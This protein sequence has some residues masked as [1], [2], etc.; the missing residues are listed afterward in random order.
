ML[1]DH[2]T[3]WACE[4]VYSDANKNVGRHVATAL[5]L[6]KNLL[7]DPETMRFSLSPQIAELAAELCMEDNAFAKISKNVVLP[8]EQLWIE[9]AVNASQGL[10]VADP[11][12]KGVDVPIK[13]LGA[14]IHAREDAATGHLS[15]TRAIVT[16]VLGTEEHIGFA[17]CFEMEFVDGKVALTQGN[18]F[19]RGQTDIYAAILTASCAIIN[20]PRIF[21]HNEVDFAKLNKQRAK[22][23]KPPLVGYTEIAMPKD[24]ARDLAD[25]RAAAARTA[26]EH[27]KRKH[28][29]V[30][31]FVRINV[32][33]HVEIVRPHWRGNP[34]LG[35]VTHKTLVKRHGEGRIA[36]DGAT[37]VVKR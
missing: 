17:T 15:L 23:G 21:T 31:T 12:Y 6:T 26:P 29:K 30:R 28:H 8:C 5:E 7:D 16:I 34:A 33:G 37:S 11:R 22:K 36:H 24:T 18:K 4:Q 2:F 13:R 19:E 3:N 14:C 25:A 20:T 35:T 10:V 9:W 32:R 1:A 27:G